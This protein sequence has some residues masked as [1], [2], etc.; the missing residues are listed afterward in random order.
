MAGVFDEG[1][2]REV[3]N[4]C[5]P[6]GETLTA[7]IHGITLQINKKKTSYFD[8]Y[9]G[10]TAHCLLV[11]ECEG[12]EYLNNF[13]SYPRSAENGGGGR[14]NGVPPGRHPVLRD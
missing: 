7:G 14:G 12:R 10:L 13:L 8:V 9:I 11:A 2:M 5:V 6:E 3:L 1:K 4:Q